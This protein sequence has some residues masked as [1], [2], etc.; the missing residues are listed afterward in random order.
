[1]KSK[2]RVML[3]AS[4]YLTILG[5]AGV[6][7]AKQAAS[8][9]A[10]NAESPTNQQTSHPIVNAKLAAANTR[11]SFKLF[12]EILKRQPN[13][14]IFISPASV[15]IALDM[16]YNGAKGET[17]QAI[18]QTIELQGMSLQELNQA[19]AALK[20]TLKNLD[21][22]VQLSIAN[23]LWAREDEPF[24]SEFIQ[25]IQDF[26]QVEVKKLNFGD[27]TAPSIINDWVKQST[28]GKINKIV[29]QIEPDTVFLL[30]NA[31]YFKGNWTE[32]F[33]KEA[34]QTRPFT[35]LDGTQKQILMMHQQKGGGVPYYE[36]E[37]FQAISLP[38][39]EGRL[40]MYIFLPNPGVSL[41]TFYANLT[42]ENW[43]KWMNQFD[44]SVGDI[45]ISL[46]RFKLEYSIELKDVLKALGMEIAFG[47]G[48]DF[49]AMTPS[50]LW[51]SKVKHKSC[52]EVNEEGTEAAAVTEVGGVRSGPIEMSVDRPFFLAIRD[53]QTGAIL[54]MGS[55]VEPKDE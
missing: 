39:G 52:V 28:N 53:N 15:A 49:S 25:S 45:K 3:A 5:L 54:F 37:M 14:N 31:I 36:N 1:M 26:Y 51:L 18:A 47:S 16:V 23:S 35:L 8:L 41:K 7:S 4:I 30:L 40:S 2:N 50:S 38:Y 42:A 24:K 19:N 20:A 9:A 46:P 21:P 32:P 17:Q 33:A 48:A 29:E 44:H 10:R 34:T 22:K 27:P 13:E 43:Q 55:I 6:L 12:S 11:L